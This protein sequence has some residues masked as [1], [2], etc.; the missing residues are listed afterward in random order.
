MVAL[1]AN[2]NAILSVIPFDVVLPKVGY[3]K[4]APLNLITV[5]VDESGGGGGGITAYDIDPVSAQSCAT[6]PAGFSGVAT[7]PTPLQVGSGEAISAAYSTITKDKDTG[8]FTSE[9]HVTSN[10]FSWDEVT[11]ILAVRDRKSSTIEAELSSGFSGERLGSQTKTNP[12]WTDAMSYR[13][14]A[15][16]AAQR[17]TATGLFTNETQGIL[18][19]IWWVS[20]AYR[21]SEEDADPVKLAE[22]AAAPTGSGSP[23]RRAPSSRS[24]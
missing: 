17:T 2:V 5:P 11:K 4:R 22:G 18:Q 13:F 20:A 16:I 14:V 6:L 19:R 1:S 24:R 12:A 10:W 15:T 8:A 21:I 3:K 9:N 7:V 23:N